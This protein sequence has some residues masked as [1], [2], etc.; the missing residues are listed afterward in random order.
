SVALD[1]ADEASPAARALGA[2]NLLTVSE[3]RLFADNTDVIGFRAGLTERGV[4][5]TGPALIVGAGGAA[6]AAAYALRE[7]GADPVTLVN[8][9]DAKAAAVAADLGAASAPWTD[10]HGVLA[11]AALII[12]ATTAGMADR[13]ALDLDLIQARP[14]AVVYDLVYTPLETPLL[15]A[16]RARGLAAV[17]GLGMLI[18]Q[19]RPSFEAFFGR[20]PP[21]SLDARALLIAALG[22]AA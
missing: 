4:A 9:T 22:R 5:I 14:E 17:D 21:A 2:A 19:A 6:R 20:P 12:N 1:A 15:T 11:Q 8:R 3:D 7:A 13:P 16:A 10:R 18:G